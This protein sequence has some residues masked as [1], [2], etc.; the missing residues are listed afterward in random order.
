[1]HISLPL[2]MLIGIH[3]HIEKL[4]LSAWMAVIIPIKIVCYKDMKEFCKMPV[5]GLF[6]FLFFFIILLMRWWCTALVLVF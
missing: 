2:C 6:L 5:L 1:M 3:M 4:L